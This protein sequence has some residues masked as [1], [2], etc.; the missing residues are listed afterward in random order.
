VSSLPLG[1]WAPQG[2]QKSRTVLSAVNCLKDQW[3]LVSVPRVWGTEVIPTGLMNKSSEK[4]NVKGYKVHI[5]WN[6]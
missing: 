2:R 4:L 6:L 3:P 5:L 1:K